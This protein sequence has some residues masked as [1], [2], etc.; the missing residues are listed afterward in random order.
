[1]TENGINEVSVRYAAR[2][3]RRVEVILIRRVQH[4]IKLVGCSVWAEIPVHLISRTLVPKKRLVLPQ[5]EAIRSTR[6]LNI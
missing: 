4:R 6:L 2:S 1:M 3:C 5:F